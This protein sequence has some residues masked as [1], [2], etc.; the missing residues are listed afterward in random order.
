M[1]MKMDDFNLFELTTIGGEAAFGF[2][3][4]YRVGGV[5]MESLLP[6]RG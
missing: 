1:L 6:R 5:H 2:G 4:A 3:E